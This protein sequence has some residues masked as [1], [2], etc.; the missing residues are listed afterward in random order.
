[1]YLFIKWF[2]LYVY[3]I[4]YF[5]LQSNFT[6]ITDNNLQFFFKILRVRNF[7]SSWSLYEFEWTVCPAYFLSIHN[8]VKCDVIAWC[9]FEIYKWSRHHWNTRFYHSGSG[10]HSFV[11]ILIW[12]CNFRF[13]NPV[14]VDFLTLCQPYVPSLHTYKDMVITISC[15]ISMSVILST[16]IYFSCFLMFVCDFSTFSS[17][18]FLWLFSIFIIS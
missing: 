10:M 17:H 9:K 18:T 1:M 7:R 2:L 3:I 16:R 11:G 6:S 4:W 14:N 5:I 15:H 13:G 12:N 8:K